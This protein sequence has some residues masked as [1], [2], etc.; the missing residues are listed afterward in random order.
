M[1]F[2]PAFSFFFY[3]IG[4]GVGPVLLGGAGKG[5]RRVNKVQ[6]LCTHVCKCKNDTC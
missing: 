5:Y 6:V 4:G 1:T 2:L 3:K